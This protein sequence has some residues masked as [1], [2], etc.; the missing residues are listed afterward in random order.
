M[1]RLSSRGKGPIE[2][3]LLE[4]NIRTPSIKKTDEIFHKF[5]KKNFKNIQHQET[6][7]AN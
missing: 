6:Q 5:S 3:L 4:R 2:I 7:P 1:Q